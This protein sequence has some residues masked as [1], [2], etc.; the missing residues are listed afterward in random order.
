M[1]E[2][3]DVVHEIIPIDKSA[4]RNNGTSISPSH[5]K[6][7]FDSPGSRKNRQMRRNIGKQSE[8]STRESLKTNA[9][10]ETS[11]PTSEIDDSLMPKDEFRDSQG[12]VLSSDRKKTMHVM[13]RPLR[14]CVTGRGTIGDDDNVFEWKVQIDSDAVGYLH[15]VFVGITESRDFYR[16]GRTFGV[17]LFAKTLE[18]IDPM[19]PGRQNQAVN[20]KNIEITANTVIIVKVRN[21]KKIVTFKAVNREGTLWSFSKSIKSWKKVRFWG[22]LKYMGDAITLL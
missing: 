21:S 19:N 13:H 14:Q 1:D 3:S 10:R 2:L 8:A 18:G 7:W 17:N 20:T 6:K 4:F 16:R 5:L 11:T 12:L 15:E 9:Q 22:S